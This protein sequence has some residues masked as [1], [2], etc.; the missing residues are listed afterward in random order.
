MVAER[1]SKRSIG[2]CRRV[3]T[4]KKNVGVRGQPKD[5]GREEEPIG[6]TAESQFNCYGQEPLLPQSSH[7]CL[8]LEAKRMK[9]FMTI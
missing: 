1:N 4:P 6:V 3:M 2:G 7:Q 8:S 9:I 5:E